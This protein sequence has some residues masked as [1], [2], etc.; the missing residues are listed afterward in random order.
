MKNDQISKSELLAKI[1]NCIFDVGDNPDK[2]K[3]QF[4]G[5]IESLPLTA[6]V[7]EPKYLGENTAVG[8]RI[9][10]CKCGNIVR[11]YHNFCNECGSKLDWDNVHE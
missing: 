9:G 2:V 6:V 10:E 5:L 1:N 3:A 4:V 11:S 8:C 7:C